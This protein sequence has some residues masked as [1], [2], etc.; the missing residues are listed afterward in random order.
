[1]SNLLNVV[2]TAEGSYGTFK[3]SMGVDYLKKSKH[4]TNSYSYYVGQHITMKQVKIKNIHAIKLTDAA[5]GLL[6]RD[7]ERFVA[8]F[9]RS[10]VHN[11]Q[12]GASFLGSATL[13]STN[14]TGTENL[15]AGWTRSL[16]KTAVYCRTHR[17]IQNL[18][19]TKRSMV[20]E[21]DNGG[22]IDVDQVIHWSRKRTN[23]DEWFF[24]FRP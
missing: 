10:F 24:L 14:S 1:M 19:C 22:E 2:A 21:L 7:P 6:E 9:G 23:V 13:T 17:T 20:I 8:T 5:F 15:S 18:G 16:G 11:I 4:S 12:Y 3:G